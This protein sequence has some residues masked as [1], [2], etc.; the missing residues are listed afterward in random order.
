M[1]Q[2]VS[3]YKIW[4]WLIAGLF[5]AVL[6]LLV[7][8]S[9]SKSAAGVTAQGNAIGVSIASKIEPLVLQD[10]ANGRSASFIVLLADQADLSAAYKMKDQ[11]Q[12]GWYVLNTLRDHATRTQAGVKGLLSS[13]G[14]QYKSFWAANAIA[15][16]G[17][18]ALVDMLAARTDVSKIE[19]NRP[20]RGIS[21]IRSSEEPPAGD[22]PVAIE[23][24]VQNVRAHDVWAMGYTGQG[25]VVGVADTGQRWTHNALKPHYRGWDGTGADHNYNWWDAIHVSAGNPC[26]V[27]SRVPCDDDELLGG[28]HGTH[29]TGTA[30]GDD[31]M[32]NQIGVAPGAKWVGC[33]NLDRG[34]GYPLSYLECFQFFLAPTDL[35]GQNPDPTKRPHVEN[36]SWACVEGCAPD[37]LRAAVENSRASGIFVEAS[38]GNDGPGCSTVAHSPAIYEASFSTG[39]YNINNVL[40]SFSS[41]GPVLSD[42]SIRMKP[43]ISAP[44][45]TVRS[46]LRGSDSAYGTL[47]GTSMAGPHVVGVVALLWSARPELVRQI[48]ETETILE[49]SANPNMTASYAVQPFCGGTP[50]QQIPNNYFGYGRVDALA[51]VQLAGSGCSTGDRYVISESSGASIEQ[52]LAPVIG[53]QCD[54]CVVNMQLPF[55][56]RFYGQH[57]TSVNASSNGNLQFASSSTAYQPGC[58]PVNVFSYS[59]LAYWRDLDLRATALPTNG[60]YTSVSG[61]APNR[62][63]NIEWK[64]C[65]YASGGCGGGQANFEVRLYEGQDRFEIVYG[66]VDSDGFPATVGAQRSTGSGFTQYS[67]LA[68]SYAQ[69][70]KLTFNLECPPPPPTN[71]PVPTSVPSSTP[72]ATSTSVP[73]STCNIEVM[74][75]DIG[76]NPDG[77]VH[78]T[79]SVRNK[80]Q[81]TASN[82]YTADL[83]VKR[84]G[85]GFVS[86]AQQRGAGSFPPGTST[87]MG[88]ICYSFTP[89]ITAMRV[90]VTIDSTNPRCVPNKKSSPESPCVHPGGCP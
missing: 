56:A 59:I 36:N 81:C 40:A 52:K 6:L 71:T 90:E 80:G 82:G 43:N 38:A 11:D 45:V 4:R 84:G 55:I 47:S 48:D 44:G 37:T 63:F 88:D 17:D 64:A 22:G 29:T 77:T 86:V 51:A 7:T 60:I 19:A 68:R 9:P 70:Q 53:S 31:G 39:A 62:V 78:W 75:V 16:T 35:N 65:I 41:R 74:S 15:V 14:L 54:D 10:T 32:G 42:G 27:D 69:G 34:I 72:T 79:A 8:S 13:M 1:H 85:G 23:W 87:A 66:R 73:C 46:S 5:V 33:R 50:P 57:F 49:R 12:R 58:L 30:T 20:S 21:P 26:G 3:Q 2:R 61:S 18:R 83:Q 25:I 28:G 24:G 89:D 76:C 67:C